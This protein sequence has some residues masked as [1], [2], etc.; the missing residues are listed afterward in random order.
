MQ[1]RGRRSGLPP[2]VEIP[3][4]LSLKAHRS[5]FV[6]EYGKVPDVVIEIVSNR[7]GGETTTKLLDYARIRVPYYA[8]YD[9]QR[10]LQSEALVLYALQGTHYEQRRNLYLGDVGLGL[11]LWQ[12][13]FEGSRGLWLRWCDEHAT[14]IATGSER[15]EQE[16]QRA[17]QERQRAER[18]AARLREL[19]EDP[20]AS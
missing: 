2:D 18:L 14:P 17:E 9:P 6:W 19:G 20:E 11:V 15:A 5:Y 3:A 13:V 10:L 4:D 12:G 1:S 7:E 8:V 16:R